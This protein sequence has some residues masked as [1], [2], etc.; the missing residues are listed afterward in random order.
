MG[1]IILPFLFGALFLAASSLSKLIKHFRNKQVG[2]KEFL[3]AFTL[4]AAI[5]DLI[6][7]SYIIQGTAWALSPPFRVLIFMVFI[8][9]LLHILI[10]NSKKPKLIS[11]SIII[12][13]SIVLT[14]FF[15]IVLMRFF[16]AYLISSK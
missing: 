13:M 2:I 7:L 8:P 1:I 10:E 3:L 11:L 6:C 4:S 5:F 9:Y 15:G 14:A 16:S 12:L